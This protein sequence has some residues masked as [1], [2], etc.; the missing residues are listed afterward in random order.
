MDFT[1]WKNCGKVER[2][3]LTNSRFILLLRRAAAVSGRNRFREYEQLKRQLSTICGWH[4][5]NPAY[6]PEHYQAGIRMLCR[7]MEV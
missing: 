4:C 3:L 6:G 1:H 2:E 7:V 5:R